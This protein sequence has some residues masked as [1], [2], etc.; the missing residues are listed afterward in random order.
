MVALLS[1]RGQ[2]DEVSLETSDGPT[3]F[4]DDLYPCGL[5]NPI[6]DALKEVREQWSDQTIG[7][8]LSIGTG[9]VPPSDIPD[10]L[11]LGKLH[12]LMIPFFE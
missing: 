4:S 9:G 2:L 5:R 12:D 11:R 6:L 10:I 3:A 8:I 7:L 1:A